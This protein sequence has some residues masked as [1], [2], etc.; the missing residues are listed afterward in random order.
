MASQSDTEF[1]QQLVS[2]FPENTDD[3]L[4]LEVLTRLIENLGTGLKC[5]S[6]NI[7]EYPA[8][9]LIDRSTK[10]GSGP[11]TIDQIKEI[12][13]K[14]REQFPKM[15]GVESEV[16]KEFDKIKQD[17][18]IKTVITLDYINNDFL[19]WYTMTSVDL[20]QKYM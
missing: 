4:K 6:E 20:P 9:Y 13:L 2:V 5:R 3:N 16:I 8:V 19:W 11:Y 10:C 7:H 1:F 15:S 18:N 12:A 17:P 14:K